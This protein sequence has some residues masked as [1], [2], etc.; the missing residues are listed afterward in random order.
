MGSF[1]VQNF[2][3]PQSFALNSLVNS[4]GLFKAKGFSGFV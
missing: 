4:T 1:R 3:D 2:F